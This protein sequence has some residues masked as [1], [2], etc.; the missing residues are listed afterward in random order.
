[1]AID[2][3]MAVGSL[4]VLADARLDQRSIFHS[5]KAKSKIFA[6][7][8]QGHLAD[9]ALATRRIERRTARVV[10]H[11]E[12]AAA[13]AWNPVEKTFAMVAPNRK[14]Q[15]GEARISSGRAE[16]KNVLLGRTDNATQSFREQLA[17]PRAAGE[18]VV[19]G[20]E[21]RSVGEWQAAQRPALQSLGCH[22]ELPICA[23]F[24]NE[25]IDH[26]LATGAGVEVSAFRF[27]NPPADA[28]EIYL[29]PARFHPGRRKLLKLD[30]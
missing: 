6:N 22:H 26:S 12:A 16:E 3:E 29:P 2:D 30:A 25:R 20:F 8:L 7:P 28:R 1:M 9:N 15:V 11:F 23:A 14:M 17:H 24:G 10:C 27:E 18:D 13:A 4:L 5:G 21:P 19:I